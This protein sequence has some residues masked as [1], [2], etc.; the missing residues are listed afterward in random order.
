MVGGR[1]KVVKLSHPVLPVLL[2]SLRSPY[3]KAPGGY[4]PSDIIC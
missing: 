4:L 3:Q 2:L 1:I